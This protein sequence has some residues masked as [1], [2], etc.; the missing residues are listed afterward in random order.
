MTNSD[1]EEWRKLD[2]RARAYWPASGKTHTSAQYEVTL[3][4]PQELVDWVVENVVGRSSHTGDLEETTQTAL[5]AFCGS[6]G[7]EPRKD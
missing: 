7:F 3:R 6:L 5:N 2:A 1:L 4:L